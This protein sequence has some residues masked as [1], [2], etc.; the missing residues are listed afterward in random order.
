MGFLR[1]Y[2]VNQTLVF[3]LHGE[4]DLST[5]PRIETSVVAA[6]DGQPHVVFDLSE[7]RYLDSTVLSFLIRRWKALGDRMEVVVPPLSPVRKIF[8]V[9]Q[10]DRYLPIVDAL[11]DAYVTA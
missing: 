6:T 7:A 3:E 4:H 10:L 5:M 11:P 9:T 8:T 1:S 2:Q